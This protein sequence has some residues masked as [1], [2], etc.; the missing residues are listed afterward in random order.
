MTKQADQLTYLLGML[1]AEVKKAN[2]EY[3]QILLQAQLAFPPNEALEQ[4]RKEVEDAVSKLAESDP[5]LK[6]H[7]PLI[8]WLEGGEATEV[9]NQH[10]L[11]L[12]VSAAIQAVTGIEPFVNPLHP[13]NDIR[14]PLLYSGI[15][16]VG[17]GPISGYG[18]KDEWV[19][20]QRTTLKR[21]K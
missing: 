17:F 9:A 21:S 2:T 15:P 8:D 5:W 6:E 18:V 10:P 3:Q 14:N 7:P 11:Y 13:M 4:V 1:T 20:L 12:T 19:D 16:T